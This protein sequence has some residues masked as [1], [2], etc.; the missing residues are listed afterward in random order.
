MWI[1]FFY[2]PFLLPLPANHPIFTAIKQHFDDII[3]DLDSIA[4]LAEA[5]IEENQQFGDFIKSY[6]GKDLDSIVQSLNEKI[7]PLIDCQQCGNCCKTLM[8]V[9]TESEANRVSQTLEMERTD[10]DSQYLEKGMHDLMIMNQM[11]CH[12][13]SDNSCRIYEHRFEGC[14]EFPALD[15]PGF[16]KRIFT[17]FM[18]YDR[19]PIIFNVLEQLKIIL[20]FEH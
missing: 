18:H 12:F 4:T 16:Q 19:C 9:V 15:I 3:S 13:L 10:F 14:R 6:K 20:N 17:H 11:P 8:I 1:N 2:T 7:Q 5:K